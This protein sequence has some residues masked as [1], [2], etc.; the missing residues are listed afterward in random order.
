[1][2]DFEWDDAKAS[3]NL[4]KH[5][6]S[7]EDAADALFGLALTRASRTE[8]EKRFASLCVCDNVIML[9]VWTFRESRVRLISARRARDN[10]RREFSAAL[11]QAAQAR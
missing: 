9:V 11:S 8:P 1:M 7:F 6:I 2:F 10:E 4:A 5:R 3:S